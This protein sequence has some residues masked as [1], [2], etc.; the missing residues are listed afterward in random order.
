MLFYRIKKKAYF[1]TLE[2][3]DSNVFSFNIVQ[4]NKIFLNMNTFLKKNF[5]ITDHTLIRLKSN[6]INVFFSIGLFENISVKN[7]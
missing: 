1:F 7:S 3:I 5:G 4:L 2:E 6:F